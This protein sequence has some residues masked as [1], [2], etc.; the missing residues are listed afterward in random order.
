MA[1]G[2]QNTSSTGSH[3]FDKDLVKDVNDFHLS[4]ASWGHARNAI[5]NSKTGDLGKIGNEPANNLCAE[6]PYTI[7]GAIHLES[8]KWAIFSTNGTSS[9]IGLFIE[10]TCQYFTAVNAPCLNFKLENLIKGASRATSDCFYEV[11]WDDGLNPSRYITLD[12]DD[13]T[14]N[15]FT[16]ANSP[17]PWIQSC[18]IVAGCN[19]CTN[20]PNL[21]CNKIRVARLIDTPCIEVKK[22]TGGGTLLNGSYFVSI[23]YAIRGQKISDYYSSNIQALFE[24]DNSSCSLD[25]EILSMDTRYDE[26]LVVITSI[27]NQQTVARLA[28]TYS[29]HQ[30]RLSFDVIMNE[31]PS[32]PIE[33]IP[34]MT[35]VDDKSDAMYNVGAYLIRVGPTAKFDFNYQPRA[36]QIVTK[37]VA[38]EYPSDYYRKGG[39][40]T[41]YLRD[42]VY[43]FFVRWIYDTGDK[44][45]S[46]HIPGR[47]ASS[48]MGDLNPPGVDGLPGDTFFWQST[49]T[50]VQVGPITSIPL[51]DGGVQIAEGFMGYWES[52]EIYPDNLPT[53]WNSGIAVSPYN[54]GV[55]GPILGN[56]HDLCGK[57]IRHHKFP[58]E[59]ISSACQLFNSGSGDRIRIMAVKFENVLPPVDNAGNPIPGIVGYEILRGTRNGNKTIIA[60]GLINNMAQYTIE[61]GS[62]KMGLYPNYPYNDLRPDPF[63]STNP[64]TWNNPTVLS[65]SGFESGYS[66]Q[67][68]FR[69]DYFTFHSPDTNFSNPFLSPRELKV[70][71]EVNGAVTGKFEISEKHPKEKLITNFAFLIGAMVGV[72]LSGLAVNGQRRIN[73]KAPIS[74]GYSMDWYFPTTE[75]TAW[76]APYGNGS[77]TTTFMPPNVGIN[78]SKVQPSFLDDTGLMSAASGI[79]SGGYSAYKAAVE[80]G[81][82]LGI[83][84]LGQPAGGGSDPSYITL[85]TVYNNVLST[86]KSFTTTLEDIEQDDGQYQRI[87][88]ALRTIA[89]L[90]MFLHY[91]TEGTDNAMRLIRAVVRFRDHALRYHSH[92]LYNNY[93][94][95]LA[96]NRR[97]EINN[98]QYVGPQ[99]TDFNVGARINNIYRSRTVATSLTAPLGNPTVADRTR[100]RV[101]DVTT[102]GFLQD[103]TKHEIT[104]SNVAGGGQIASSHYVALKQRIDNQYDQLINI[105]QV[106]VSTCKTS[107]INPATG[108]PLT[109]PTQTDVLFGGDTYLG[110]YTEK[111]SFFYFYEWLYNQPDGAQLDYKAHRMLPHPR[112]WANFNEFETSDFTT[113]ALS[114]I[115]TFSFS[116]LEVPS[117]FYNL[118]GLPAQNFTWSNFVSSL[119]AVKLSVKDSWFY[120]FN[121]GV[122]DFFV[123]SEINIDLRD[124]GNIETEQH[125]D[126]YRYTDTKSLFDTAI[127]KA[128]N[129]YKYDQSLSVARLFINYVS[130]AATQ[131]RDY[132]PFLAET[133]YV[134]R[135]RRAIYSLPAQF[136]GRKDNWLIFLP[137]NYY[138]FLSRVTCIK[139]INKNG[140]IIF[141]ESD[142]PVEFQGTDQLQ[143]SLGTKLTIGDGGLFSQPLQSLTNADRPYEYGSCQDRLSVINTPAGVFWMS[144]NQGKV[145]NLAGGMK[146]ISN[147]DLKWWF[148]NYLPYKLTALFPTFQ[149]TDNPVIGIGCQAVYDN[150]NGLAYFCKKDYILRTGF[151]PSQF[152]YNG[153]NNF[154]YLPTGLAIKLG[155][156]AYFEDA[157]WTIS[158]DPKTQAWLGWH[159]WHP[160]LLM[161]GKNTFMSIV[162]NKLTGKG[163]IWIHN[164]RCDLYCNYYG[165]DY[166][167]EIEYTVNTPQQITTLRSIEYYLEVYKYDGNCYDR[168]HVL[169][170]NFDEAVIYNTEQCSG[171]LRMNN[172]PRNNPSLLLQYPIINPT[173]IDILYSKEENKYR[174]NQFW[175]I[176][177]DRGEF[178][179]YPA[180]PV[181][182]RMIWNTGANG[183]VKSLNPANLNYNKA[184]LQR[185]KFRHYTNSVFLRKRVIAGQQITYKMLVMITNNKQL[186]SPR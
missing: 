69:Q 101:S 136:E 94:N 159:D 68:S 61:G 140:A 45:A 30:T 126:P 183:Y 144:Q 130:W 28:G 55:L 166:P 161:P 27:V 185:K 62:P 18:T 158:F 59:R 87:P 41:N 35:P 78:K 125:Y 116:G 176:T 127:I 54:G 52:T 103:P 107:I 175:D 81:A 22:G 82:V 57:K 147:Q 128:G 7:I 34:L 141:F 106:P 145:F 17:I 122:R 90:P 154:T 77:S 129:Y 173:F 25:V 182:Q 153:S 112:Y 143:T 165:V 120:L 1:G 79:A 2:L 135:P 13:P 146:E 58:E 172:S 36:N 160:E 8:N 15:P 163:G 38:V 123:E 85:N 37:W 83:N 184:E 109:T 51:P 152:Q 6:A 162:T 164:E 91:F 115:T 169:D 104:G 80:N 20:T 157:S 19:I 64:T 113:S 39:N 133:C 67:S 151:T 73:R 118:D 138:D 74:P 84:I 76:S 75:N 12:V 65:G 149:L 179:V 97:R 92:G 40:N 171:M 121:S 110:R 26:I 139:P 33:Q 29:T 114:A 99:L 95:S 21:D 155:D 70:Y 105:V 148:T 132:N 142:S 186:N 44:S 63:L 50:A 111:N 48:V 43:P 117:S 178:P 47:P 11:Y 134:Y 174:F 137:N 9:E 88:L 177:D 170:Y 24:H 31:W 56:L 60:K 23:A 124:W 72:G 16:S 89:A 46:Y 32:V 108:L 14:N 93:V 86:T 168:F 3:S 100:Y 5:N 167:F 4:P 98:L 42:E 96:G 10:E 66:P 150:E 156:P 71:G 102:P 181:A 119:S 53:V 131:N 180:P 49:N